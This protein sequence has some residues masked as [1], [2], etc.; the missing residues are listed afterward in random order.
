MKLDGE[1][2]Q[3]EVLLN[4]GSGPIEVQGEGEILFSRRCEGNILDVRGA[5]IRRLPSKG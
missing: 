2:R 4:C 1:G 3:I 5:L